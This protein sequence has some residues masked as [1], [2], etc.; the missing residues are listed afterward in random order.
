MGTGAR[1]RELTR[2]GHEDTAEADV[3]GPRRKSKT[4]APP[5]LAHDEQRSP[6]PAKAVDASAIDQ[7]A[8]QALPILIH[9][10]G[11]INGGSGTG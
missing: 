6:D 4:S 9:R 11:T 3:D 10:R 7:D 8:A 1:A 5:F 2:S